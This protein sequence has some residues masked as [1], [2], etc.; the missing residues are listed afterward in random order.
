MRLMPLLLFAGLVSRFFKRLG[1]CIRSIFG[2]LGLCVSC[3][4]GSLGL[5]FQ[6]V[7]MAFECLFTGLF[8][9]GIAS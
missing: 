5:G 3:F 4:L 7:S 1:L 6:A 2:S 9:L 8:L